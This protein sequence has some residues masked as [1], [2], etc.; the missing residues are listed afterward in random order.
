VEDDAALAFSRKFYEV[1]LAG[2]GFGDAA[3]A[4]RREAYELRR[5]GTTWG[6]YL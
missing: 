5:T 1:I 2:A 4:A 6:A 3:L